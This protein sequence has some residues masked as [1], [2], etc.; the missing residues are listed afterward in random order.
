MEY[1]RIITRWNHKN[2][3]VLVHNKGA[4]SATTNETHAT[5]DS[6]RELSNYQLTS[7]TSSN[8]AGEDDIV[9]ITKIYSIFRYKYRS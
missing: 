5:T 3:T 6:N 9:N 2:F 8:Y 7:T 4:S 1:R